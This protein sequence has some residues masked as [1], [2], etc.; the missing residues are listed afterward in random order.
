MSQKA[1]EVKR[2]IAETMNFSEENVKGS[3]MLVNDLGIDRFDAVSI[4]LKINK[5]F[6]DI[7]LTDKDMRGIFSVQDLVNFVEKPRELQKSSAFRR[8]PNMELMRADAIANNVGRSPL[9][10]LLRGE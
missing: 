3:S 6:P 1:K 9:T 7:L 10:D 8:A 2:I 5:R 4:K